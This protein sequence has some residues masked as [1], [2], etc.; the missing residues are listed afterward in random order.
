MKAILPHEF[1]R[2]AMFF[3]RESMIYNVAY[4]AQSVFGNN[5]KRES[6]FFQNIP[7]T[8]N[9]N[10]APYSSKVLITQTWLIDMIYEIACLKNCGNKSINKYEAL[11]LIH[12]FNDY[13]NIQEG[14]RQEMRADPILNLYG[15]FGEQHR[16]QAKNRFFENFSREKYILDVI[17]KKE[18]KDNHYGIDIQNNLLEIYGLSSFEYTRYLLLMFCYFSTSRLISNKEI[19]FKDLVDVNIDIDIFCSLVEMFSI[20]IEQIKLSKFKRQIFYS[21]PIIKIEENY[22]ASNP[23][24]LLSMFENAEYWA[25]RNYYQNKSST[26]FTSA[27]GTYFEMYF[28]EVLSNCLS[29]VEYKRLNDNNISLSDW[30]I[31]LGEYNIIIEQKATLSLLG[32]KQTQPDLAA[33]KKHMNK[34]WGKAVSQL[35]N[36]EKTLCLNTPIKMILLYEDYYKSECLDRLFSYNPQ[37]KNDCRYWLVTINEL[38]IL[39]NLYRVNKEKAIEIL[40]EKDNMELNR[41]SDGRDLMQI[42]ERHSI[43]SNDYLTDFQIYQTQFEKVLDSLVSNDQ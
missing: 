13:Q 27:F 34:V 5:Q 43:F 15:F 12:L 8:I 30:E 35:E 18:H 6:A 22:V 11:H 39:L 14:K 41:S 42:F 19:M 25:I 28:E 1:L 9:L 37:F 20:P 21:K 31:H 29:K 33:L 23:F 4:W 3:S 24:L 38:E 40:K 16:F 32:S 36:T 7:Y 26:D 2:Y 17:S 10:G